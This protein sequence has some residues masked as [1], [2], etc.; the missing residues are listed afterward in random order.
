M[1][2]ILSAIV[3]AT[4]SAGSLVAQKEVKYDKLY[5]KDTK[6]ETNDLI[7][8]IDGAVSLAEETKF[9]LKITNKT[10]DYIMYKPEESKF[11]IDGKE[12]KIKEKS[13]IIAPNDYATWVINLKG[14]GYNRIKNYAFEVG[15][16]YKISSTPPAIPAPD[17]KL[18]PAQNEFTAGAFKATLN[19][20]SKETEKTEVK[21]DVAYNGDKIGFI[22]PA[23][24]SVKMP[25]GNE[26]ANNDTKAKPILL[27]KGE[28][29]SFKL[30]WDRMQGGKSMDMQK[31]EMQI[32]W[33][34]TFAEVSPEKMKSETINLEFDEATSNA[35]K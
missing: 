30:Q 29:D 34:A 16:L 17:F 18:P 25:D 27:Q 1:K 5:Y 6:I 23:K 26:Y 21:F 12:Q 2:K 8:E 11:I 13:K 9:K 33:N 3:I 7:I 20:F 10:A 15:G 31:V 24:A 14:A 35:K 19:K 22:M 28:K 32:K 4:I